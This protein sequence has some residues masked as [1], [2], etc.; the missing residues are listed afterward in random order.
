MDMREFSLLEQAVE[1][2]CSF[3]EAL[4]EDAMVEQNWGPK[5]VLAH[6]VY[7]HEVYV[8]QAQSYLRGEPVDLPQGRYSDLNARAVENSRGI[9][10]AQLTARFRAANHAL[11]QISM[12]CDPDQVVIPIKSG[13]RAYTL[14][15][16]V[17]EVLPHIRNHHRKLVRELRKAR[18]IKV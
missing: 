15:E 16:L 2:F 11:G 10:V 7:W 1:A 12:D 8:S 6:L 18:Q 3:I 9:P 4:P 17:A 13:V 14:A 5:E